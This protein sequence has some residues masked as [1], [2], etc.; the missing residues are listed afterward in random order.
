LFRVNFA[1]YSVPILTAV[2]AFLKKQKSN[3]AK[4][5]KGCF[6]FD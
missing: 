3:P 5:F 2:F 4:K 1:S 6:S